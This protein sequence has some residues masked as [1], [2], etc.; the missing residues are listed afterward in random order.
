MSDDKIEYC[1]SVNDEEFHDDLSYVLDMAN[2]DYI[3][4][5][6][7]AEKVPAKHDDY[8]NGWRIVE[9]IKE[10]AYEELG[11][12]PDGYLEDLSEKDIEDLSELISNFLDHKIG[13]PNFYKVKNSRI[14]PISEME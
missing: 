11:E 4:N 1:W 3:D 2:D 10:R 6:Y 14:V 7:E 9:E 5:I 13:P 12:I 8:I